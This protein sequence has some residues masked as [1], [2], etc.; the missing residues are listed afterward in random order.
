MPT[1]LVMT[2]EAVPRFY[3]RLI[4]EGPVMGPHERV[5]QPGFVQNDVW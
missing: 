1:E 2:H 3:G 4:D 5:R